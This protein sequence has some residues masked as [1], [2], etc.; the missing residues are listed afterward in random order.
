MSFR[1]VFTL[2]TALTLSLASL[3]ALADGVWEGSW[4]T[5]YLDLNLIQDGTLVY[6]EYE[7]RGWIIG[8]TDNSGSVLRGAWVYESGRWGALEFR[9]QLGGNAFVGEWDEEMTSFAYGAGTNWSGSRQ[10][11]LPTMTPEFNGQIELP[12]EFDFNDPTW[13]AGSTTGAGVLGQP[14]CRNQAQARL[15]RKSRCRLAFPPP[16]TRM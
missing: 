6:G 13:R 2:A 12:T 16:T 7:G 11:I 5:T 4:D 8:I 1:S 9:T 15:A 14:P 10:S 3:A